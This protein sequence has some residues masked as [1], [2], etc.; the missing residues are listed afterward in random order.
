MIRLL[1]VH[2]LVGCMRNISFIKLSQIIGASLV[3][4]V[5]VFLSNGF[6]V[7]GYASN[8]LNQKSP[9]LLP[10]QYIGLA[11][12]IK[13]F[14]DPKVA[15]VDV[16]ATIFYDAGHIERAINLPPADSNS[17]SPVFKQQY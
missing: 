15:I 8:N 2:S 1:P 17:N 3:V 10:Y 9:S 5:C 6:P 16:R 7:S 13:T 12:A 4:S 11:D 14:N